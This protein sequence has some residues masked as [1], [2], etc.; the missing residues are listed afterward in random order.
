M[1]AR[2]T[3]KPQ[4]KALYMQKIPLQ[5]TCWTRDLTTGKWYC[6]PT[7]WK[8]AEAWKRW[9]SGPIQSTAVWDGHVITEGC[10]RSAVSTSM[11]MARRRQGSSLWVTVLPGPVPW[12]AVYNFQDLTFTDQDHSEV[13]P[14]QSQGRH[15]K[16]RCSKRGVMGNKNPD[17]VWITIPQNKPVKY[18]GHSFSL[19]SPLIPVGWKLS[20]YLCLKKCWK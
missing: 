14:E 19:F 13:I 10:L 20:W 7:I 11:P 12:E 15:L 1:L 5:R 3:G 16:S 8:Q 18:L 17:G 9:R 2:S 6:K 4:N